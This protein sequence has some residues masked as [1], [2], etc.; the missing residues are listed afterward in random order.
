MTF[1]LE[2][3]ISVHMIHVVHPVQDVNQAHVV[4]DHLLQDPEVQAG[5]KNTAATEAEAEGREL[6]L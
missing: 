1:P 2:S 5:G 6:I 3:T 4:Q